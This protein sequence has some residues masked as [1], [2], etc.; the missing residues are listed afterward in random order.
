MNAGILKVR[1]HTALYGHILN[2]PWRSRLERRRCRGEAVRGA[3]LGYLHRY[4]P[5]INS[6]WEEETAPD[7]TSSGPERIFSV[8]LQGEENAPEIVKACFRSIRRNCSQQ[9]VVLDGTTLG[10]WIQLPAPILRKWREGKI[11]PAHFTD[12]CRTELL[13]RYGG[14]W[15]D[16]TAFVMRPVPEEILAE[17]F[18][19]YMGGSTLKG[20]YAFV[21]NCFFRAVKGNYLLGAW[22]HAIQTYWMHEDRILDYFTHQL[23][24]ELV[25][26]NDRKAAALFSRMPKVEQD[27]T[28]IL[29]FRH[30]DEPF[31]QEL[32]DE[33]KACS[34]FQKTE[35][36]SRSAS[37]PVPGSFAETIMK[38]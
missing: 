12:I 26:E 10:K 7:R 15:L 13:Y 9:L 5:E 33:V 34:F 11:R 25:V 19:I 31:S 3:V 6:A 24:F 18:F 23:L 38:M 37:D 20:S 27:P 1:I 32:F 28:H 8:W 21:Q 2:W 16:A 14:I 35:Y 17:D 36:K 29:W 30:R 22:N 4:I